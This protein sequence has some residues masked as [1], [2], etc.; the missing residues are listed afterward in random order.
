LLE[1]WT[2]FV[3]GDDADASNFFTKSENFCFSS[4]GA[5]GCACGATGPMEVLQQAE[6]RGKKRLRT[7]RIRSLPEELDEGLVGSRRENANGGMHFGMSFGDGCL[8]PC[9][10]GDCGKYA[11]FL[12]SRRRTR[13]MNLRSTSFHGHS[14]SERLA[15]PLCDQTGRYL[16]S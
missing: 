2:G 4:A 5:A 11:Q 7:G 15:R 9:Y 12:W 6:S 3:V 10:F 8:P 13:V 14:G 16:K 1:L